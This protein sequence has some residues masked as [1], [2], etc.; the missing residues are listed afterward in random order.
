M[1][2]L[3]K[4]CFILALICEIYIIDVA[5][6]TGSLIVCGLMVLQGLNVAWQFVRVLGLLP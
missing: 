6:E 4:F 3:K 1:E 5:V 2:A